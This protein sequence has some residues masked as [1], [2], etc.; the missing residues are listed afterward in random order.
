M[1]SHVLLFMVSFPKFIDTTLCGI[2]KLWSNAIIDSHWLSLAPA[3]LFDVGKR[4]SAFCAKEI[5]RFYRNL[6]MADMITLDISKDRNYNTFLRNFL[7]SYRRPFISCPASQISK[8]H[9]K[10]A[11]HQ[12]RVSFLLVNSSWVVKYVYDQ[13]LQK[14]GMDW[15]YYFFHKNLGVC[16][17]HTGDGFLQL[18]LKETHFVWGV[19]FVSFLGQ[20]KKERYFKAKSSGNFVHKMFTWDPWNLRETSR[21]EALGQSE[22]RLQLSWML[23]S[24]GVWGEAS[25]G[26]LKTR[27]FW[28]FFLSS[29]AWNKQKTP[30][31]VFLL[32]CMIFLVSFLSFNKKIRLRSI[33]AKSCTSFFP[34]PGTR[35]I[36][37]FLA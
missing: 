11:G 19:D 22:P 18:H 13:N 31:P 35:L 20:N 36:P 6:K 33:P 27:W 15:S 8:F 32:K 37:L 24:D 10:K 4:T 30:Q 9:L 16:L 5:T 25:S 7:S 29:Q 17:I 12:K 23:L 14:N 3:W 1:F 21:T 28:F 34:S 2:I 26:W